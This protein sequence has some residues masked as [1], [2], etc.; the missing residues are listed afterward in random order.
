MAPGSLL[1]AQ[2]PVVQKERE[3]DPLRILGGGSSY[4]GLWLLVCSQ[5]AH[6]ERK[7]PFWPETPRSLSPLTIWWSEAP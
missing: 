4:W 6:L 5:T 3:R 7:A 1:Q 2:S